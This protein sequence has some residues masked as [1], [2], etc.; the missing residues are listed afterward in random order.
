MGD[1]EMICNYC[2]KVYVRKG[3]LQKH[4]ETKH[5]EE[6]RQAQDEQDQGQLFQRLDIPENLENFPG[7]DEDLVAAA[8]DFENTQTDSVDNQIIWDCDNCA[9]SA[10]REKRLMLK[11]KA[12]E[13]TKRFLQK[14]SKDQSNEISNCRKLLDNSVKEK[15]VLKA[16]NTTKESLKVASTPEIVYIDDKEAKSF[17]SCEYCNFKA[18]GERLL[19]KHHKTMHFK[20]HICAMIAV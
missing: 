11:I 4:I 1:S 17:K 9:N 3:S 10:S 18:K 14:K 7:G 15:L 16:N 6:S 13:S 2:D 5:K 12:L 19:H 8:E 20:C